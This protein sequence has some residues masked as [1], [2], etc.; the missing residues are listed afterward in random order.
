[1]PGSRGRERNRV[2]TKDEEMRQA[3]GGGW[4]RQEKGR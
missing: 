1:M 4:S 2:G 3:G